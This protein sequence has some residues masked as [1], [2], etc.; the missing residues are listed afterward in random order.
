M[1]KQIMKEKTQNEENDDWTVTHKT[2]QIRATRQRLR[3]WVNKTV[4]DK[5]EQ[6]RATKLRLKMKIDWRLK[7]DKKWDWRINQNIKFTQIYVYIC[8]M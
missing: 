3:H 7:K 8:S 6:I 2:E 5:T 1:K 4:T